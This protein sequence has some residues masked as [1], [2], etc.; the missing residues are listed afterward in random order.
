MADSGGKTEGK[1]DAKSE[2]KDTSAADAGAGKETDS[3]GS[4]APSGYS[5]GE[6]QKAVTDAFRKNWNN[7]FGKKPHRKSKK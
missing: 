2:A 4:D 3:S 6:N 1:T 7:I 5:S